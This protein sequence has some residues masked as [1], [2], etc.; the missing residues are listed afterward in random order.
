MRGP[1]DGAA[2]AQRPHMIEL[3]MLGRLSVTGAAGREART[4]SGQ[5]RRFA[6]LAYLAAAT[7]LAFHRRDTLLALFWPELDQEHARTAL[8]QAL[9]VLRTTLGSGGV[10]GRG[11]EEV[12]L[13]FGQ[14]WSDV[15]A[16]ERAS[17][18]GEWLE[19]MDL[20]RGPLLEGF[21]ISGAPDFERWL[22]SARARLEEAASRAAR[23][24]VEQCESQGNLT[25]AT[26]WARRA[27]R[28]APRDETR[29]RRWIRLLGHHGDRARALQA[30]EAFAHQ[31]AE[32]YAAQ[33]AAETQALVAAVRARAQAAP[34]VPL[35]AVDLL[36]RLQAGVAG[37]YRI[38]RELARG[39]TATVFVAHDL[40]H[41]RQG[42][43]KGLPGEG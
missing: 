38:D 41:D 31:L 1:L 22:E 18:A 9:R 21:F 25:T 26:H 34:P 11:D 30:Y 8:R 43:L 7:P 14:I 35:P 6:S 10:V 13:D 40:K 17:S 29:V 39:R 23:A 33:P 4:R 27:V 42:A 16:F 5:P 24:L 32:D 20:Y 3:R 37:R 2:C 15:T 19:A 12:S 36:P 28:L